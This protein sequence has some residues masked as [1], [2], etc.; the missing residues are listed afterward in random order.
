MNSHKLTFYNLQTLTTFSEDDLGCTCSTRGGHD[1]CI[2]LH[3]C[4]EKLEPLLGTER[5]WA[6]NIKKDLNYSVKWFNWFK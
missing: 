5:G 2:G 6:N 4:A 3:I 1:K